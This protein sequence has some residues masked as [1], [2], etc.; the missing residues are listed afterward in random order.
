VCS[1]FIRILCLALISSAVQQAFSASLL[2]SITGAFIA[3]NGREHGTKI[4][5]IDGTTQTPSVMISG[6][7]LT[8]YTGAS[9]SAWVSQTRFSP[10]GSQLCFTYYYGKGSGYGLALMTA[11]NNGRNVAKVCD[12]HWGQNQSDPWYV[13]TSWC[14]DGYIYWSECTDTIWRV[15]PVA[16]QPQ[17]YWCNV[18]VTGYHTDHVTYGNYVEA[19]SV[20]RDGTIGASS[21]GGVVHALDLVNKDTL[22]TCHGGC[23]GAISTNGDVLIHWL[24]AA[25]LIYPPGG[26]YNPDN[27]FMSVTAL[28]N[29]RDCN[30]ITYNFAPECAAA[31]KSGNRVWMYRG[32]CNSNE[33]MIGQ[34]DG[35]LANIGVLSNMNT[36]DW[37]LLPG[38]NAF[39]F[40]LGT[41]PP[42]PAAAPRIALDSTQ[43]DFIATGSTPPAVKVVHVSNTGI[44]TLADVTVAENASW[45]TVTRAGSGNTQTLSNAVD[46]SGLTKG[47]Y[48][49]TVTVSGGGANNSAAYAV[50]LNVGS[51]VSAPT[52]LAASPNGA[53]VGLTWQDNAGDENGYVIQRSTSSTWTTIKLLPANA[54]S[55]VDSNLAAAT[56]SYRVC[57]FA[58]T[59][60]SGYSNTASASVSPV[61]T[62]TV[63][64]PS[65]GEILPAGSTY[66][67]KW[68]SQ[69]SDGVYLEY[70][71]DAGLTWARMFP[72]RGSIRPT[73]VDWQD[74]SWTVP[75]TV[76]TTCLLHV[77]EYAN[78]AISGQSGS[79]A[80]SRT[81]GMVLPGRQGIS[82]NVQQILVGKMLLSVMLPARTVHDAL[83]TVTVFDSRGCMVERASTRGACVAVRASLKRGVYLLAVRTE[84]MKTLTRKLLVQ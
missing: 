19:L 58:G 69:N 1:R 3:V 71:L 4:Y 80:I 33:W 2:P 67:V 70:S 24:T 36:S 6:D 47:A 45:L 21:N 49:T 65:A 68:T 81:N 62:I 50:T 31:P 29:V 32:A 78:H 8:K 82:G 17:A 11:D 61:I 37:M 54:I 55:Y 44:G 12:L 56:Y 77:V 20:S 14:T 39:D 75:D 84:G 46:Q 40:W 53:N 38:Y 18:G 15:S 73:D 57:A 72:T 42:P 5:L 35:N 83:R 28:Q 51:A 9:G 63:T 7:T 26:V 52:S 76:S 10:D 25:Y 27:A 79:F 60:T 22:R 30:D 64:K 66:P 59:D 34:G 41:L 16:K 43:L 48:T 23:R 13:L 74:M